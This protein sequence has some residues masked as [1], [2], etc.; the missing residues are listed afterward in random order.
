MAAVSVSPQD[1]ETYINQRLNDYTIQTMNP[2]LQELRDMTT[3][4]IAA[5][6]DRTNALVGQ[7]ND[8]KEAFKAVETDYNSK[9]LEYDSIV[10][11]HMDQANTQFDTHTANITTSLNKHN[12]LF[13]KVDSLVKGIE[14][15]I[16]RIK[17]E[18][19]N[20]TKKVD[21]GL[22]NMSAHAD[23]LKNEVTQAHR[24]MQGSLSSAIATASAAAAGGGGGSK[25]RTLDEDKRLEGI[26]HLNG[27]ETSAQ[28]VDW[29]STTFIKMESA[30]PGSRSIL[31][32]V[33]ST[34][35]EI[36]T[37]LIDENRSDDRL[38]AH[39]LNRELISWMATVMK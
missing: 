33:Q 29:F 13:Q 32:W 37:E 3:P 38:V 5:L 18:H 14:A 8:V 20:T 6:Q 39:R 35:E 1:L 22:R 11:Q 23:Q 12:D 27:H 30:C 34:D 36:T 21:E 2:K 16:G 17:E 19:G 15:D 26:G 9:M 24:Q 31:E 28:I 10:K 7:M 4:G 25:G